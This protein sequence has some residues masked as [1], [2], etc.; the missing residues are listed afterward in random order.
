VTIDGFYDGTRP[1]TAADRA[2]LEAL[3]AV[4]PALLDRLGLAEAEVPDGRLVDQMMRPSFN[5]RG[6]SAGDVGADA[7]NVVPA[8]ATASVDIRLAAGNENLRVGQLWYGVDL[9][10]LLLTSEREAVH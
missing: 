3:P 9:W 2:A 5:L 6:P 7:R 8:Q 10:A 4:E 1:V